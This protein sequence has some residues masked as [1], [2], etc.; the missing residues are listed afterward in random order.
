[1][2]VDCGHYIDGVRQH[3][4]AIS[5]AQAAHCRAQEE[6]FVWVGIADPEQH[7][8]LPFKLTPW[9]FSCFRGGA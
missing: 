5:L 6:G 3:D 4:E 1:M 8:H 2:I 7:Y 9:G